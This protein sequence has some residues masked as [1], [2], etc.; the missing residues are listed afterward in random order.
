MSLQ[1]IKVVVYCCLPTVIWWKNEAQVFLPPP[2]WIGL[3]PKEFFRL[4]L[5]EKRDSCPVKFVLLDPH[6]NDEIIKL[7][8]CS[9]LWE[10]HLPNFEFVLANKFKPEKYIQHKITNQ[11][12]FSK[13]FIKKGLTW[14][15]GG[16]WEILLHSWNRITLYP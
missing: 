5:K 1:T 3:I 11:V 2:L 12:L 6:S 16:I 8:N 10:M 15:L 14:W 13:Y 7:L 4:R 9:W